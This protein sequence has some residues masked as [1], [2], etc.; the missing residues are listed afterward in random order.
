MLVSI[1]MRYIT[2]DIHIDHPVAR[3][4]CKHKHRSTPIYIPV[5]SR[6]IALYLST[7]FLPFLSNK[8]YFRFVHFLVT[9]FHVVVVTF[10]V[11]LEPPRSHPENPFRPDF[12]FLHLKVCVCAFSVV[13]SSFGMCHS[14]TLSQCLWLDSVFFGNTFFCCTLLLQFSFLPLFIFFPLSLSLPNFLYFSVPVLQFTLCPIPAFL[15]SRVLLRFVDS[16]LS[17]PFPK[18]K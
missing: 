2:T 17:L 9:L 10:F 14:F 13:C 15:N 18:T 3:I 16:T 11:P 4:H 8:F 1:V 12:Y 6:R 7:R 5:S